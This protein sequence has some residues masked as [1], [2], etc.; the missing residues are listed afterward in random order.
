MILN[1]NNNNINWDHYLTCRLPPQVKREIWIILPVLTVFLRLPLILLR[2]QYVPLR[3][4]VVAVE[5]GVLAIEAHVQLRRQRVAQEVAAPDQVGAVQHLPVA[6][7]ETV[8]GLFKRQW[9]GESY[10]N[11]PFTAC[12]QY[13]IP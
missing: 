4:G 12:E 11:F 9:N 6:Y 5:V 1:N 3:P 13:F 8:Q 2:Q 7:G 10:C